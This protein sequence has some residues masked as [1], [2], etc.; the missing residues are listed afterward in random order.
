[1]LLRNIEQSLRLCNGTRS[2]VLQYK[3]SAKLAGRATLRRA[4]YITSSVGLLTR[5]PLTSLTAS[6]RWTSPGELGRA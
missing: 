5:V 2:I 6:G 3:S 1:M 4:N